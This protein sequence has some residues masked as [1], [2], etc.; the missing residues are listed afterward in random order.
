MK[1]LS[2]LVVTFLFATVLLQPTNAQSTDW[3]HWRGPG[4]TGVLPN[5]SPPLEWSEEKN[6]QWKVP[7]EGEGIATPVIS[8]NKVFLLTSI[9][10]DRV[11]PGLPKPEDQPKENFFNIKKPNAFHK[12]VVLCL[13]R[14]SG[15]E[16]WRKTASELIPHEGVHQDNKFASASPVIDG[17]RVYC[18]FGS[19]GLFCYESGVWMRKPERPSGRRNVTSRTLGRR[20]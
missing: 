14:N 15:K 17:D 13:D 6:V 9:K 20:H 4:A 19:A 16:R 7:V 18:W 5:A 10:T 2:S 1:D 12:F 11:D 8:G 3:H